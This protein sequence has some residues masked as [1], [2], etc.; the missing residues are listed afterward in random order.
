MLDALKA[1]NGELLTSEQLHQVGKELGIKRWDDRN[2]AIR[3]LESR[4][5]LLP[6]A[7]GFRVGP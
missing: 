4:Q 5:L 6:I 3:G 7:G 2:A 1:G